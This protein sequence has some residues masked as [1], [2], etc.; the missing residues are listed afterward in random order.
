[1]YKS[2]NNEV[3]KHKAL[4]YRQNYDKLCGDLTEVSP[5]H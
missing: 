2:S 5:Q 4:N 1:M 3:Y